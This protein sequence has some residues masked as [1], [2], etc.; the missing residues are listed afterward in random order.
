M[1]FLKKVYSP[2]FA[3]YFTYPNLEKCETV[4]LIIKNSCAL[5]NWLRLTSRVYLLPGSV[6]V[7]DIVTH[8]ITEGTWRK[9]VTLLPSVSDV[10]S[11]NYSMNAKVIRD[12]LAKYFMNEGSVSW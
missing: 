7:E 4:N 11:N 9:I 1:S 5:H 8:E 6:D 10:G 2:K 3:A 12:N